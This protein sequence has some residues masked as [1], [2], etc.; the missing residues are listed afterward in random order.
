MSGGGIGGGSGSDYSIQ[1][2]L[3]DGNI[4]KNSFTIGNSTTTTTS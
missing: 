2:S 1:V 3:Y 4:E